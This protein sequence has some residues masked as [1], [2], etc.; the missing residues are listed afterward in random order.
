MLNFKYIQTNAEL[1]AII[2]EIVKVPVWAYDSETTGLDCHKDKVTLCQIGNIREQYVIDARK[3]SLEPLRATFFENQGIVKIGHNLKFDYKMLKG[4]AGIE[5]ENIRDTM[6][7]DKVLNVGRKKFGFGLDDC[8]LSWLGVVMDKTQQKSF[9]GHTGDFSQ[10]QLC[11]AAKDVVHPIELYRKQCVSLQEDGLVDTYLLEC[12]VMS[13]FAD[14]EFAGLKL[15]KEKWNAVI[16]KNILKAKELEERMKP[17]A[18]N[19]FPIDLFGN[20]EIN[21]GSP[22][23]VVELLKRLGIRIKEEDFKTGEITEHGIEDSSDETLKKVV[24]YPIVDLL[25]QW[26]SARIRVNTFGLPYLEAIHPVTG[27]IHPEFDQL[28]TETG[29]PTSHKKSPV[30]MLNIPREKEMR[31]CFV[32]EEDY[33][34][35]TDDY[36]GCE[37]RIWAELSQDPNLLSPIRDGVD[38]HC[39]AASRLF[40]VHVTKDNENKALR[41]PAKQMNFGIIYGMGPSRLYWAINGANYPISVSDTKDLYRKYTKEEFA[42]G[43]DF[44]RDA[45]KRAYEQG[46]L[47]NLNGR[48][49][50][51]IRP[52]PDDREKFPLGEKDPAFH[53]QRVAIELQGGNMLVQS[54]NADMTKAAMIEVRKYKKAN[55]TRTELMN[56]VYDELVT[57]TH[58]DE[59]KHFQEVKRK[60]MID[61]SKKWIKTV[62][63]EVEGESLPYWTK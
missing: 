61:V 49:R 2:P 20:V 1:E 34:V 45:G 62:P 26:R 29:R 33:V 60:I 27:R 44:L 38:L 22:K 12:Q 57:T 48:R 4:T 39:Y 58:K 24:G 23:Q 36:S 7:A 16:Q 35:E 25:K 31:N 42:V 28:G 54:V 30:N 59:S 40:G 41:V 14:M 19:F 3:V 32:A 21:W 37:L 9:I 5:L 51:W 52:N 63:I 56:A 13:A 50:Y 18:E 11:Y 15:D 6:F 43:V 55:R 10:D 53:K 17:F 46:Y 8:L 47:A